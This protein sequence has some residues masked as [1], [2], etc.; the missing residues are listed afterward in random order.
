MLYLILGLGAATALVWLGRR[1]GGLRQSQARLAAGGVAL[2]ALG[3]AI[4]V[5]LRGQYLGGALLL[6]LGAWLAPLARPAKPL[7]HD[8]GGMSVEQARSILGV[9]PSATRAEIQEAYK[10]LMRRA[11]PDQGGTSGLASQ[12]NAARDRLLS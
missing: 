3:G 12:L 2:L 5:S 11:H 9:G 4:F 8:F 6:A 7:P 1:G 10:R